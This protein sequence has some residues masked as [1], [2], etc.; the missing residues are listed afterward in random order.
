MSEPKKEV[1]KMNDRTSKVVLTGIMTSLILVSTMIFRIHIPFTQGYVHLG[2]A[3]IFIAVLIVG[4]K[5]GTFASGVGS[6]LADLF[7][8]YAY[9]APWTFAVKA[10]MAFVVGAAL[11]HYEKKMHEEKNREK[12]NSKVHQGESPWLNSKGRIPTL[13]LLAMFFG[14]VEMCV[15]YYISAS[16]MHGNWYTPLFSIPGNI[17]QFIVGMVIAIALASALYKTPARKYFAIK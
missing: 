12:G 10:L 9:Y 16:L 4:K 5:Y 7:S 15:G 8:G 1:K 6:A 13:E 3:A 14:G 2:D 17:A 11:E